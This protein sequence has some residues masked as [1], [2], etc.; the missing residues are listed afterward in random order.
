MARAVV[1][2]VCLLTA[3]PAAAIARDW[4]V[5]A[6]GTGDGSAGAPLGTI[7]AGIDAALPGDAVVIAL[8]TYA[9]ALHTVRAGTPAA[10]IAIRGDGTG[11]VL[12]TVARRV[13]S[14]AHPYT[15]VDS[16]IIDAQYAD[17]D[18]VQLERP[19]SAPTSAACPTA[20][21]HCPTVRR[22]TL[23]PPVDRR[24]AAATVAATAAGLRRSSWCSRRCGASCRGGG[25]N[26]P[27]HRCNF[28]FA[29][30][31]PKLHKP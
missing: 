28:R 10:P 31:M 6:G 3:T 12:V 24:A 30:R 20:R 19:T 11:D 14:I 4:F 23:P 26:G 25:R 15:I 18:A 5:T 1:T 22:A 17:A 8:G 21:R 16:V 2:C 29:R 27:F 9:E 7:Q 13:L